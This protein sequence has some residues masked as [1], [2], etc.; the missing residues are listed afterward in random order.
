MKKSARRTED[1][2]FLDLFYNAQTV[3]R[4]NDLVANLK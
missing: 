3:V 1:R 4:V 2:L